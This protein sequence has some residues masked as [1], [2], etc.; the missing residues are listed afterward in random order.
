MDRSRSAKVQLQ[1]TMRVAKRFYSQRKLAPSLGT[2]RH[3]V[4]GNLFLRTATEFDD[5]NKS[6]VTDN[7]DN[8]ARFVSK[9]SIPNLVIGDYSGYTG[10][11]TNPPTIPHTHHNAKQKPKG[12]YMTTQERAILLSHWHSQSHK[13]SAK[14]HFDIT[15][16]TPQE[17]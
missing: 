12:C 15:S 6:L 3:A 10:E 11:G 7:I 1:V 2:W 16:P 8:Y 9:H 5:S 4:K 14:L 13:H 17:L